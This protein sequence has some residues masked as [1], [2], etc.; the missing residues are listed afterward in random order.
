MRKLILPVLAVFVFAGISFAATPVKLSLWDKI[1]I[2]SDDEVIGLEFGIGS[3]TPKV[4]G[5]ALNWLYGKSDIVIGAQSAFVNF[6]N[7]KITGAQVGVFNKA[8]YVKGAQIG[9][10][11]MTDDMY[12]VQI[13]IVN[14]IKSSSL[15]W[16]VFVNAKF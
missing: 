1:A 4:N 12:G 8:K 6:N 15:P 2:P 14:H 5:L 9:I 16:M 7:E 13:G 11:N 3:Y 10:V